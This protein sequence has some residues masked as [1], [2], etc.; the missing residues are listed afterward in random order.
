MPGVV[1]GKG[2][3]SGISKPANSWGT[4]SRSVAAWF[5]GPNKEFGVE[6]FPFPWPPTGPIWGSK[7]AK[8]S[9][10]GGVGRMSLEDT[11]KF[12]DGLTFA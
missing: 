9:M 12:G 10:T 2:S 3:G 1:S 8:G 7:G 6:A 11:I 5:V 4:D